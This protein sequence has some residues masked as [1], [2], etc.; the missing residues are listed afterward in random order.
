MN[1]IP[2]RLFFRLPGV[3]LVSLLMACADGLR[4]VGAWFDARGMSGVPETFRPSLEPAHLAPLPFPG[5]QRYEV[6]WR[7]LHEVK[8][9]DPLQTGHAAA[10][11]LALHAGWAPADLP[12]GPIETAD[13]RAYP[14]DEPVIGVF[15]SVLRP[16]PDARYGGLP[17][18]GLVKLLAARGMTAHYSMKGDLAGVR[19]W[20]DAGWPVAMLVDGS[21]LGATSQALLWVVVHG[22]DGQQVAIAGLPDGSRTTQVERLMPA[23]DAE[24]FPFRGAA[25]VAEGIPR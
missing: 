5:T 12:V 4:P 25:V 19:R 16:E 1:R 7:S 13:G 15:T 24:R 9:R 18:L 10:A 2:R 17:P 8:V 23:W 3:L 6:G 20:V 21:R 14:L 11:M 22:I